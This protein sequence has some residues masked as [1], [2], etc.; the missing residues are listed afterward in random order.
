MAER[1]GQNA[2]EMISCWRSNI[3]FNWEQNRASVAIDGIHVAYDDPTGKNT[4]TK[5]KAVPF[6]TT[7]DVCWWTL[8]LENLDAIAERFLFWQYEAPRLVFTYDDAYAMEF[9]LRFGEMTDESTIATG[10]DT[11][12]KCV[13]RAPVTLDGWVFDSDMVNVAK[14]IILTIYD[15]DS[16]DAS[17]YTEVLNPQTAE[18]FERQAAL[19]L[20]QATIPTS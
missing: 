14:K 2:L 11:G 15:E 6:V 17:T 4:V 9:N 12:V 13:L 7:F 1:R 8:K 10:T 18:Q 16:L 5:I 19:R 3:R 20:F